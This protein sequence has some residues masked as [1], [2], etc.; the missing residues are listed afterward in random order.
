LIDVNYDSVYK[1]PLP[2]EGYGDDACK[3][4]I[5]KTLNR[6]LELYNDASKFGGIDNLPAIN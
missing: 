1:K 2:S 5:E 4:R 3:K 6:I